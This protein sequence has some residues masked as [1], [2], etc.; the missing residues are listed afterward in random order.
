M[1]TGVDPAPSKCDLKGTVND[2]QRQQGSFISSQGAI[3]AK[4]VEWE[5]GFQV[6]SWIKRSVMPPVMAA[7]FIDDSVSSP[8]V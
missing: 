8:E 2:H 6:L 4:V 7:G 5:D 3:A 1:A